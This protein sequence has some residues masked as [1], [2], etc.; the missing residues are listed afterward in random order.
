MATPRRL[1]YIASIGNPPPYRTTRHSAGHLLLD[2]LL[3]LLA[4]EPRFA[5]FYETWHS[6]S[7][8]NESG[9]KLVKRFQR[10]L[11]TRNKHPAG[12]MGS[13]LGISPQNTT[14]NTNLPITLVLLHDELEA[15][16]G[17]I[18][19]NR[20]GPGSASLRG[21]RG[22]IS[23]FQSLRGTGLFT[24][25][26]GSGGQRSG[27]RDIS[28]LRV[29]VG[30]GRPATREKDAVAGYVLSE[31]SAAE[32]AAVERKAGAVMWLLKDEFSW[33]GP[34]SGDSASKV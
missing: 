18:R 14:T 16:P 8:M 34:P 27:R 25:T 5:P 20:G 32:R 1:L 13:G 24:D 30:I 29:G 19:V 6:T 17:K 12:P 21:H 2:S 26:A 4:K 23:T 15:T 10:W 7:Y 33:E 28:V 3:P 22:L 9:P 11:D 31:M